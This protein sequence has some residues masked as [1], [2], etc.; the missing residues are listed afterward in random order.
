M[1]GGHATHSGIGFQDKAAAV[2]AVYVLANEPFPFFDLPGGVT[3]SRLDLET[4][5]PID[6]ILAKT[7]A[8]G[9]CFINVK[10]SVR[11]SNDPKSPLGSV[12]DQFVRQ[13]ITC[14]ASGGTRDWE[15][16]LNPEKDRFILITGGT[17]ARALV[18]AAPII[19]M[20]VAD[21]HSIQPRED[22]ATTVSERKAYDALVGLVRFYW[23]RHTGNIPTEIEIAS[24]L[25]MTRIVFADPDKTDKA[26]V[27][28]LLR[29]VV[30]ANPGD[31]ENAW[32]SLV[33]ECHR[34]S[35]HRSSTDRDTLR[36]TL[37]SAG[38]SLQHIPELE[39]DIHRLEAFTDETLKHLAHLAYLPI[40]T[41]MGI[42]SFKI[43]RQV[44]QVL[45]DCAQSA[46]MLLISSPGAGKSGSLYWAAKQLR[47]QGHPV[48]VVAVD[49]HPVERLEEL[50]QDFKLSGSL[51]DVLKGWTTSKPG[52]FF[53]DA[54]DATRGGPSDKVFQEL[55]RRIVAEVPGWRVVASVR[56]FDLQFGVAYREL[57]AGLPLNDEFRDP[58]FPKV[59]HLLVPRLSQDELEQVWSASPDM[60]EV[61][62]QATE[63]LRELLCNPFNLFLLANILST[64]GLVEEFEGISTQIESW[65]VLVVPGHRERSQGGRTRKTAVS[66]R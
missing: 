8:Q 25:G 62:R 36:D 16:P 53:I 20:R 6:D 45:I 50:M 59:R 21:R 26:P 42:Q 13:W 29:R 39:G 19:L 60:H 2:I 33:A 47:E 11:I 66:C 44:T 52:V 41:A 64:G 22:I 38:F 35:E 3:V 1:V 32:T 37:R 14:Q 58:A 55:I 51:F 30:L 31:A 63:A 7:S 18:S 15:R 23:S 9:F 40:P 48:V 34:L 56:E 24:L 10:K 49:R 12:V 17:G 61:Y 28:A 46:S 43:N 65:P 54:L 27:L 5:A 57:F 4:N